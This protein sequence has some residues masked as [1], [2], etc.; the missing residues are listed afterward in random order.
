MV[1]SATKLKK[2]FAMMKS[3]IRLNEWQSQSQPL[4]TRLHQLHLFQSSTTFVLRRTSFLQFLFGLTL[5]SNLALFLSKPHS[6]SRNLGC[7]T[8][9]HRGT[10]QLAVQ[11]QLS[12]PT[13]I[14]RESI[15][16]YLH[17]ETPTETSTL[18]LHPRHTSSAMS[19]TESH[20][21]RPIAIGTSVLLLHTFNALR[22]H[23]DKP[24]LPRIING[25]QTP[26]QSIKQRRD[27]S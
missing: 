27:H 15:I 26:L 1:K 11:P 14:T 7:P 24:T 16:S 4:R 12:F 3:S 8:P 25:I 2:K 6:T 23:V 5:F 9:I 17:I 10:F 22:S 21:P 18:N 13:A 19:I 20:T